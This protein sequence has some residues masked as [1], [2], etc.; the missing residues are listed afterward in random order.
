MTS[1]FW[2]P[3]K[4]PRTQP[5]PLIM[6]LNFPVTNY[7]TTNSSCNPP[8]LSSQENIAAITN[9]PIIFKNTSGNSSY[10]FYHPS[11]VR[12]CT[13]TIS[14]MELHPILL[15][16]TH[17]PPSPVNNTNTCYQLETL[18]LCQ[19]F[20]HTLTTFLEHLTSHPLLI[21]RKIYRNTSLNLKNYEQV[22]ILKIIPLR[23]PLHIKRLKNLSSN[24]GD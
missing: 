1:P 10:I 12:K 8:L 17:Q 4:Q 6:S 2:N 3:I 18:Q 24:L 19:H 21:N 14:S 22:N 7:P 23:S 15:L 13:N 5:L 11:S 16:L 20:T 9:E